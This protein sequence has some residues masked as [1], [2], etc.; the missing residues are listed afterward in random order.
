V[1]ADLYHHQSGGGWYLGLDDEVV[2]RIDA[3]AGRAGLVGRLSPVPA[4]THMSVDEVA[5]QNGI[6]TSPMWWISINAR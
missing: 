6:A 3:A 1:P 4:P 5:W 2:Y